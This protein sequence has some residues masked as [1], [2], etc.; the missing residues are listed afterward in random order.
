MSPNY[1]HSLAAESLLTKWDRATKKQRETKNAY[2]ELTVRLD[3][4][5][6]DAWMEQ[7]E[8][9]DE[10]GGDSLKIFNVNVERGKVTLLLMPKDPTNPVQCRTFYG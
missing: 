2:L 7:A 9:A 3:S 8:R 6:V 1:Y 10:E 4:D 5:W